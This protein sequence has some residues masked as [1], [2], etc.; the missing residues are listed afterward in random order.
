MAD[1]VVP[2][3]LVTMRHCLSSR[4]FSL[5]RLLVADER[6]WCSSAVDRAR[7]SGPCRATHI[8]CA[9]FFSSSSCDRGCGLGTVSHRS[10]LAASVLCHYCSSFVLR[11][12]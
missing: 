9:I 12:P 11:L 6:E 5:E 4:T 7:A 3:S 1:V 8:E 2:G 10:Q